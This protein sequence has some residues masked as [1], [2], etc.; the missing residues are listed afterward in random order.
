MRGKLLPRIVADIKQLLVPDSG[1]LP[2]ED[3]G[4]LW[5]DGNTVVS[6]GRNWSAADHLDI[7]PDPTDPFPAGTAQ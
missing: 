6:G 1:G 2:D 4:A 5:D 7:I 3:L